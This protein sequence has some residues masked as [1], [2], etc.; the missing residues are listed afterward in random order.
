M[1][2]LEILEQDEIT[3]LILSQTVTMSVCVYSLCILTNIY[4]L[5]KN[6]V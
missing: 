3:G 4:I 1:R 2:Y 5:K 6:H